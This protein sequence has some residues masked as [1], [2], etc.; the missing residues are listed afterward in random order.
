MERRVGTAGV[1]GAGE[2]RSCFNVRRIRQNGPV[3]FS[4]GDRSRRAG[5]KNHT[6]DAIGTDATRACRARGLGMLKR[7]PSRPDRRPP[8]GVRRVVPGARSFR[9]RAAG[10]SDRGRGSANR[11]GDIARGLA[12]AGMGLLPRGGEGHVVTGVCGRGR[13]VCARDV[14]RGP[15]LGRFTACPGP[16][17][18]Q[19][20]PLA[21][22]CTILWSGCQE[23]IGPGIFG[24]WLAPRA[25]ESGVVNPRGIEDASLELPSPGASVPSYSG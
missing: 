8:R 10:R 2:A 19:R 5:R 4:V 9:L 7:H 22:K 24:L 23:G 14:Y 3:R 20:D 1:A 21:N 16:P 17:P 11:Q 13:T 12:R 6:V 15:V 25:L 18:C